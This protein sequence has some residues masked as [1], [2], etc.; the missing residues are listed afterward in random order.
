MSPQGQG[1]H[2][3]PRVHGGPLGFPPLS[4]PRPAHLSP[5]LPELTGG[6]IGPD[7]FPEESQRLE[8]EG[9]GGGVVPRLRGGRG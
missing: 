9:S 4:L 8:G 5:C 7:H 3:G 6:P 2:T 1:A